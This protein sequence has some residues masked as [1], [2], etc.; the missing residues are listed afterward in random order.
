MEERRK[1]KRLPLKLE[2]KISSL[3]KQDY[4]LIPDVNE[5]ITVKDIS[6]TGIGFTCRQQLPL[7]YYFD[8]KIQLSQDKYFY[9]VIKIIRADKIEDGYSVGCEFV[10]LADILSMRVDWY[11]EELEAKAK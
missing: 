2:L 6:K 7:N 10:G 3:F 9:A 8:A 11:G 1:S 4:E 5:S